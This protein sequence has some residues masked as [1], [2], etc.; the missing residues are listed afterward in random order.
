[1]QAK[2]RGYVRRVLAILHPLSRHNTHLLQRAVG[3][4]A[5][6]SFYAPFEQNGVVAPRQDDKSIGSIKVTNSMKHCTSAV[7]RPFR[8]FWSRAFA[9]VAALRIRAIPPGI[10]VVRA[11]PQRQIR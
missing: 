5:S 1:M 4:C 6:V 11:S 7:L 10:A 8:P 9:P 2:R 3:Q